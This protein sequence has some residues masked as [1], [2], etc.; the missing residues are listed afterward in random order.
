MRG[1]IVS[2]LLMFFTYIHIYTH[3]VMRTYIY[4]YNASWVFKLIFINRIKSKQENNFYKNEL[5]I[6]KL[7]KNQSFRKNNHEFSDFQ[8]RNMIN[9]IQNYFLIFLI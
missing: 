6:G 3:M 1:N 2:V 7:K 9:F 4:I 5:K 8:N